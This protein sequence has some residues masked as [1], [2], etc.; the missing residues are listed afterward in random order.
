MLTPIEHVL[1]R[2]D[3]YVGSLDKQTEQQWI[4]NEDETQF[5]QK[6]LT[7]SPA[8]YKIY[9]EVLVNAADNY[10]RD[11]TMNFLSIEIN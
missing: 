9:D 6:T 11:K 1:K 7:Y 3:T 2:P 4:L 8:L 10:Q 5:I